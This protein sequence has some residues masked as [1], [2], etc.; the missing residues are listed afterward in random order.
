[1]LISSSIFLIWN[2]TRAALHDSQFKKLLIYLKLALYA[3]PWFNLCLKQDVLAPVSL[4]PP[5]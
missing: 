3:A 4:K 5:F 2:S 1:M